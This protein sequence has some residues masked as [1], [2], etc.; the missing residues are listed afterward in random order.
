M[1]ALLGQVGWRRKATDNSG[2]RG[3]Q[4]RHEV[5]AATRTLTTLEVSVRRRGAAL[6]RLEL[7]G[8]HAQTHRA[9]GVAPFR[10]GLFEHDVQPLL[11]GLQ[12]DA[13]RTRHDEHAYAV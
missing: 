3:H 6:S 8:V 10:A 13:H 12:P 5:S 1:S 11:F 9:T 2:R 4:R 7:V